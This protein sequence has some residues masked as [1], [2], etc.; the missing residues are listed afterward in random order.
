MCC[1]KIG[2]ELGHIQSIFRFLALPTTIPC[3]L[4]YSD[5]LS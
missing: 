5:I 4:T 3:G 1:M 2:S